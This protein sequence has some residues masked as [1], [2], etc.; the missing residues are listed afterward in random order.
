V[1]K[2]SINIK[3]SKRIALFAFSSDGSKIATASDDHTAIIWDVTTGKE[4]VT[5]QGHCDKVNTAT[6][7]PDGSKVVTASDDHTA[8]IWP[9]QKKYIP[10]EATEKVK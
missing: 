7:S 3:H 2:F 8:I 6:F 4:L 5:L 10:S 9:I 1:R